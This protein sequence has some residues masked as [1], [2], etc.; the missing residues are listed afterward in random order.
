MKNLFKIGQIVPSSNTTMETEI[1]AMLRARELILPERFTFHSSR[2]RMKSVTESELKK[3]DA[4]SDRCA[5]EL[6]DAGVDVIGYACLVA[7]MSMGNGYHRES[8]KRL[9]ERTSENYAYA[10]IVTSAGA[11]IDGL[12]ALRA[13]NVALISPYMKPLAKM[14]VSYIGHEGFEVIENLAL[15]EVSNAKVMPFLFNLSKIDPYYTRFKSDVFLTLPNGE[16]LKGDGVLEI[17]DLR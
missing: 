9:G 16:T 11:L 3:M 5:Y 2:M 12:T 15:F 1:P 13:K 10:P 6:S 4:E 14:V 8:E 17:M 7:I